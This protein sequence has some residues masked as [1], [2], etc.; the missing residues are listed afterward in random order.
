MALSAERLQSEKLRDLKKRI[1]GAKTP[2]RKANLE[3]E[4]ERLTNARPRR[5]KEFGV[6]E[7]AKALERAKW[8]RSQ[9]RR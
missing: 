7:A 1:R 9:P 2:E 3:A 4:L 5:K 8:L 6:K